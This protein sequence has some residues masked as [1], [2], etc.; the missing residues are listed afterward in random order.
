HNADSVIIEGNRI[1]NNGAT[2]HDTG[3]AA[4]G[5]GI[6]GLYILNNVVHQ[7]EIFGILLGTDDRTN[8]INNVFIGPGGSTKGI[9]MP[10]SAGNEDFT[11][12]NNIFYNWDYGIHTTDANS[13]I[14]LVSNNLFHLVTSGRE[15]VGESDPAMVVKD[16]LFASLTLTQ[17]QAFKPLPGSPAIDAGTSA[18]DMGAAGLRRGA[19]RDMF[20]TA[21]PQGSA[22]DIGIYEGT[23]YTSAP[24][25]EFDSLITVVAGNTVIVK[26]S[27]WKLLWN[28][29]RGGGITG[30]YDMAGGDTATNLLVTNTLLFD[31]TVGAYAAS[32]QTGNTLAPTFTERSRAR[33]VV[34]QRL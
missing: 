9:Y 32:A 23:G 15:V 6:D 29:A 4:V 1:Y 33:A 20:G 13:E 14:G 27:K 19:H 24:Q 25:S 8:I 17:P 18:V 28:M 21:R 12:T 5:S 30:F 2:R 34:R 22:P 10:N 16:P 7:P 11:I 26:N 31:V 3:I